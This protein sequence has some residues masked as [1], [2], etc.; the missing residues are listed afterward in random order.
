[1]PLSRSSTR[2]STHQLMRLATTMPA[3]N[4]ALTNHGQYSNAMAT[5]FFKQ[6]RD[7]T[8]V[9]DAGEDRHPRRRWQ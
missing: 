2:D 1:M 3:A 4:P 6:A 9:W 7:T 5:Y 8:E